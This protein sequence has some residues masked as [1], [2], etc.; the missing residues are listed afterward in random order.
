[1]KL[2]L[3]RPAC[4]NLLS[5][6]NLV[7]VEPLELEYLYTLGRE[8]GFE[9]QIYD[10]VIHFRKLSKVIKQYNP[11]LVAIT[12]YITQRNLMLEYAQTAKNFN[13]DVLVIIG[14]VHAELNYQDFFRPIVNFIVHSGGIQPFRD[15]LECLS[16]GEEDNFREEIKKI[17]GICY[18]TDENNWFANEKISVI[19]DMLP[20][21]DRSFFYENQN[22]F[23]YL[24]LSPC[25]TVKTAYSCPHQCNFCYCRQL[26]GGNYV[27]RALNKVIE[28]IAGID[29]QTIWILD[30][31]FYEE[32]QRVKEFVRLVKENNLHKNYIVYYRA[33]FIANNEDLIALL[34]SIGLKV[35]IV[36]LEVFD[37]QWLQEYDKYT[38]LEINEESIRILK[39]YNLEC[40]G[41]FIVDIDA[42]K[43]DFVNLRKF[44]KKHQLVLS[45][46]AILTP[47][48]GTYQYEKYRTRIK[49]V[50]PKHWDFL[51]L[52]AEPGKLSKQR[53][54]FEFYKFYLQLFFMNK[55][56]SLLN[57]N[58][59]RVLRSVLKACFRKLVNKVNP[60]F[61]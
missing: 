23:N 56:P 15:L 30:D 20:I 19:P 16:T 44:I 13:P 9:C 61:H 26:N 43:K 45:T 52:I 37:D 54:Y 21:P 46:A 2:L 42:A 5:G 47:L 10:A 39:K 59:I 18:R 7:K 3:V 6:L 48:P 22:H 58:Y 51:H 41:L 4:Q 57:L 32:R 27:C 49:T 60:F 36:G 29:C 33:D 17:K 11:G 8:L 34:K 28:E 24:S 14:G 31:T 35:V 12:G 25:A 50:N 53:F 55:K 1:M 40:T 38:S